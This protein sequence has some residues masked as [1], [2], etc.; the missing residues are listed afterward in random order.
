M[1]QARRPVQ[2]WQLMRHAVASVVLA[3]VLVATLP[4]VV[5]LSGGPWEAFCSTLTPGSE[6]WLLY[7]C[8]LAGPPSNA[9]GV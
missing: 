3:G 2:V 7:F 9:P 6:L 4:G 5:R 1:H 8:M